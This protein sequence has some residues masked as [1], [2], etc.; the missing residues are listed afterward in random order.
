MTEAPKEKHPPLPATLSPDSFIDNFY[1][2][3]MEKYKWTTSQI[4]E[5]D[6]WLLF[7]IEFKDNMLNTSN[8][9][10]EDQVMTIDEVRR[11]ALNGEF[12]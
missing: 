7:E 10:H 5:E 12:K 9:P 6:F 3:L 1:K 11:R 8:Q 4:D 2:Y